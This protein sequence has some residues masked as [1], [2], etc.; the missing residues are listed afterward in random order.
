MKTVKIV[1]KT[2]QESLDRI[3]ALFNLKR[4]SYYKYVKRFAVRKT[5]EK[6]AA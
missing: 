3:C 1:R 4:D 5:Q 6:K 2:R